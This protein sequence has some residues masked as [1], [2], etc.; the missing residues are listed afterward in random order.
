MTAADVG[1]APGSLEDLGAISEIYGHY[2]RTSAISF[3]LEAPSVE[4]RRE[5]FSVFDTSGR[6]RLLVARD[7]GRAVAYAASVLRNPM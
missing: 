1:V 4:W 6:H 5:W 2:V 3:D 7:D